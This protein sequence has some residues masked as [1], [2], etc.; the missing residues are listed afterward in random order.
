M[1]W[2]MSLIYLP[3]MFFIYYNAGKIILKSAKYKNITVIKSIISGFIAV[4]FIN[5]IVALPIQLLRL[6]WNI[7][8]YGISSAYLLLIVLIVKIN[9]IKPS[10]DFDRDNLLSFVK[11]HLRKYWLL[12]ALVIVFSIL[13][14]ANQQPY[15]SMNYDDPYYIGKIVHLIQ[16]P[17]VLNENYFNG[18]LTTETV[19]LERLLNT[20]E[21][22]YGYFAT[23]FHIS[24]PFFCRATMVIH[25]YILVLLVYYA[26]AEVFAGK[27]TALSQ[28]VLLPFVVFI[29]PFGYLNVESF[30]HMYDGWQFQ[31]AIFYGG[32][33]VRVTA[34]PT[35][36][37]FAKDLLEKIDFRKIIFMGMIYLVMLSF[38][39]IFIQ[40]GILMFLIL[41]FIKIWIVYRETSIRSRKIS[42]ALSGGL[43]LGLVLSVSL[44][45]K[46]ALPSIAEGESFFIAYIN[47]GAFFAYGFII[48]LATFPLCKDSIGRYLILA[49]TLFYLFLRLNIFEQLLAITSF[50]LFFVTLR[51]IA[52][53]EHMLLFFIGVIL[54]K[55]VERIS[56]TKWIAYFAA[57]CLTMTVVYWLKNIERFKLYEYLGSGVN[58]DGYS[59]SRLLHN[60]QMIP[61][62][63]SETGKYFETLDYG[64]Y[65]LFL[66]ESYSYD[67]TELDS[68]G[69]VM[70][71]NRIET[72]LRGGCGLTQTEYDTA[73][74]YFRGEKT[75]SEL[76]I[77]VKKREIDYIL[78]GDEKQYEELLG[79]NKE[80]V[81]TFENGTQRMF[82]LMKLR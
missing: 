1:N 75:Y 52:S 4:Y 68:M 42:A 17:A 82:W 33:V 19:G 7:Y 71:S 8:F 14:M 73:L 56:L 43:L 63:I 39:S 9:G 44:I 34:I 81:M 18:A 12:Y 49:V 29:I 6:S 30:I 23:L 10:F 55:T 78:I 46:N 24:V 58:K 77:I 70:A 47:D 11:R 20:Y 53:V 59:I 45:D 15:Y 66:A 13:S 40:I 72:S 22:G 54:V 67:N 36:L 35:I 51:T 5:F 74:D 69:F 26:L 50:D 62:L 61:N 65:K 16:S 76:S 64:N 32:S 28:Y 48:L 3:M 60:D 37:L 41:I 79:Y 21:L 25:N 57:V 27:E 31:T 80:C 2:G 38:S